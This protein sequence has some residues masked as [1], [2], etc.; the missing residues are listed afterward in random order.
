MKIG[1]IH[2][3]MN[4][5][6]G[7]ERVV[8]IQANYW[9]K[10]YGYDVVI[11]THLDEDCKS[12]Y[13]LCEGIRI[14]HIGERPSHKIWNKMYLFYAIRVIKKRILQYKYF[15]HKENPD[16][17][18]STMHGSENYY[19]KLVSEDIPVIGINHIS[20]NLRHGD[21]IQSIIKRLI[22][23]F[24]YGIFISKLK[25]YEAIVA[26]SKTDYVRLRKNG[27]N[28]FYIPNPNSFSD[29]NICTGTYNRKK[30]IIMVGRI[31]YLKGQDRLLK[32]WSFLAN[33]NPD[34]KLVLVGDG[35]NIDNIL[36]LIENYKLKD[37]VEIICQSKDIRSLLLQSSIFAFTSRS[38][39]FGM[40]IL[41]AF[42]CGLPVVSF[43]CENGPRDLIDNYYNGFL[44]PDDDYSLFASKL[45][46]LID[47]PQ[48]RAKMQMNAFQ[49]IMRFDRD[50]IMAQWDDLFNILLSNKKNGR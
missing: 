6:G 24:L 28:S 45:Q 22:A 30:N 17:I 20:L 11:F 33:A 4:V 21:Y 42:S 49:T 1:I 38:E 48:L 18:L 37:R 27:C 35:N 36:I 19:L 3:S 40:V 23:R 39:S 10:K 2:A 43:D 41:E 25:S 46:L 5:A 44:I 16:I 8:S 50:L 12:F 15:I 9:R 13:P 47:N 26:L 14:V 32:I 34:W 31:D 29:V 7:I